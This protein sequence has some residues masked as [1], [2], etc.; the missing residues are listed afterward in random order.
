MDL[1][2]GFLPAE[3]KQ[4]ID[5][6]IAKDTLYAVDFL[7]RDVNHFTDRQVIG[8]MVCLE[9][10]LADANGRENTFF[11]QML[12]KHHARLKAFFDRHVVRR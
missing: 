7:M 8:V 9:R 10:F 2:F 5:S 6:A 3:L 1:I 12:D 4:W 11:L